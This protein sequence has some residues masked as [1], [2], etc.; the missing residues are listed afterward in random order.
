[1]ITKFLMLKNLFDRTTLV[2]LLVLLVIQLNLFR[3][4]FTCKAYAYSCNIMSK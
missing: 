1:M 2:L 3:I 4:F